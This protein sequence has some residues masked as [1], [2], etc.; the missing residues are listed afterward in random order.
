MPNCT[1]MGRSSPRPARISATWS[2]LAASPAMIAAGSPGV[3]RS[4]RNTNTATISRTGM[5]AATRLARKVNNEH[6]L[7]LDV[8]V[9]VARSGHE[10]GDAF[11]YRGRID[12]FPQRGVGADLESTHLDRFGQALFPGLIGGARELVAQFL[13]FF[14]AAP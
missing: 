14:V 11:P 8:P 1:G 13:Q 2:G 5:V 6:L 12:V 3:S 4:I 10:A 7:F 9:E